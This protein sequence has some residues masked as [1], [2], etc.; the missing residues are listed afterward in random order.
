MHYNEIAEELIKMYIERTTYLKELIAWRDQKVIKVITGMRRTGK[1]ILLGQLYRDYLLTSGVTEAQIIIV[2]L[3]SIDNEH[4]YHYRT[5]YDYINAQLIP[6]KK[7]YVIID[8]VQNADQF[9]KAVDSLYI[10]DN[11]DLYITGSNAQVLSSE[12]ATLLSGRYITIELLPLSF[13]EYKSSQ[14]KEK[15]NAELYAEYARYGGLPYITALNN[16]EMQ[17]SQYLEGIYNTVL[18]KDIII[19]RKISD[20]FVLEDVIK[21]MFDN[22]GNITSTNKISN[23]LTTHGR[24]VTRQTIDRYISYLIDSFILYKVNRYDIKGKEY[25]KSLEKYYVVDLGIRNHL[26][27]FRNIDRGHVLENIVFLELKR[28]GYEIFIGKYADKEIDFIAKKADEM[29]YIQVAETIKDKQ[30]FTREITPLRMIDDYYPR[31]IITTDYDLNKDYDGIK[32][33]N[34]YDWLLS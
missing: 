29:M 1:S 4:L 5:L 18:K 26:L 24:K 23:T 28:R 31:L 20:V 17:I 21:F 13:K 16:K 6:D 34:V 10:K 14:K 32:V 9:Q 3:E 15:T 7:N 30:T 2:N 8:E 11:V 25:L 33:V 19:K 22:I 12:L 27:G